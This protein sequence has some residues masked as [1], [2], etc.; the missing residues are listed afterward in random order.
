MTTQTYHVVL[1]PIDGGV[2]LVGPASLVEVMLN[3]VHPQNTNLME[4]PARNSLG[5]LPVPSLDLL[6]TTLLH[7]GIEPLI[8]QHLSRTKHG[9]PGR[10]PRLHGRNQAKLLARSKQLGRVH[11]SKMLLGVIKVSRPWRTENGRQEGTRAKNMA[12]AAR[13]GDELRC[14]LRGGG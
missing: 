1:D 6:A 3:P 13:E 7:L 10:V 2:R 11:T 4:R 5:K 14:F 9:K 8:L 12:D